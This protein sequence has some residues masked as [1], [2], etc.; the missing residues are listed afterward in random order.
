M[1]AQALKK[2]AELTAPATVKSLLN[3]IP[4]PYL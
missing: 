4:L 3:F 1:L 2:S